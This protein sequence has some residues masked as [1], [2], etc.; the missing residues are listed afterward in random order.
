[1]KSS[2]RLPG[3]TWI[4]AALTLVIL[5]AAAVPAAA[6]TKISVGLNT[7]PGLIFAVEYLAVGQGFFKQE[8]LDVELVAFEG[9]G[10]VIP[11]IAQ[12]RVLIGRGNA[13]VVILSR[14]A[15]RSPLPLKCFYNVVRRSAFEFIVPESSPIKTI[16]D[17]KGGKKIGVISL[18]AGNLPATRA[19]LAEAGLKQGTDF[20]F[21]AVGTGATAV[22]TFATGQIDVLNLWDAEHVGVEL[23]GNKIRHIPQPPRFSDQVSSCWMAH[24]DVI[25]DKKDVLARFGRAFA[26]ASYAC[27]ANWPYCVKNFYAMNPGARP[28]GGTEAEQIDRGVKVMRSRVDKFFYSPPGVP[29]KMGEFQETSIRDS[30]DILAAGGQIAN[31]DIPMNVIFTN[32]LVGEINR[33]DIKPVADAA[34]TWK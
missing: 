23:A 14:Q 7:P 28:T 27:Q 2:F 15:G 8:G 9:S 25:R 30:L 1:M 31:K 19:L 32:E 6:Q 24:E 20:E 17:I 13:D 4:V 34:K 10:V 18:A 33:F 5:A 21:V 11:Q 16:A 26:K 29:L 3:L 12:Q 22:R